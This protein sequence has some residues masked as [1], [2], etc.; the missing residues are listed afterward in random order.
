MSN[1]IA[2]AFVGALMVAAGVVLYQGR[3]GPN[4]WYGGRL[5]R[6]LRDRAAWT[7]ATRAVGGSMAIGGVAIGVAAVVGAATGVTLDDEVPTLLV[8]GVLV[9]SIAIGVVQALAVLRKG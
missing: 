4:I 7:T 1:F 2:F 6:S 3:L 9:G 8:L 5:P